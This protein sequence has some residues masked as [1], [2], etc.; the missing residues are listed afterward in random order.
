VALKAALDA[1]DHVVNNMTSSKH[2]LSESMVS[3][4]M[5]MGGGNE[6]QSPASSLNSSVS[7]FNR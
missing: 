2:S 7:G 3:L 1:M 4:A 5:H 6:N